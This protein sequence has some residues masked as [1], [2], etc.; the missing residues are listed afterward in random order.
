MTIINH[1]LQTLLHLHFT[2]YQLGLLL[3]RLAL[4]ILRILFYE[5][6]YQLHPSLIFTLVE[7]GN[8]VKLLI[9]LNPKYALPE[10]NWQ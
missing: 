5:E 7:E 4:E 10:S 2:D 6:N 9:Y 8:S 3:N 1:S